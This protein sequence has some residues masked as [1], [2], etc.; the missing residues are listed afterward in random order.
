MG[1]QNGIGDDTANIFN[2]RTSRRDTNLASQPRM[3]L[4]PEWWCRINSVHYYYS[5]VDGQNIK[6]GNVFF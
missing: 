4:W 1:A 3:G 5:M 2:P 6:L